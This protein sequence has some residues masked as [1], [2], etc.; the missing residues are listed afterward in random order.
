MVL[1]LKEGVLTP[2]SSQI[3]IELT[4][5]FLLIRKHVVDLTIV[6]LKP[7]TLTSQFLDLGTEE[8]VAGIFEFLKLLISL[9]QLEGKRLAFL[10]FTLHF[11]TH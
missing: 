2:R 1:L 4:A 3:L 11:S 5:L 7:L 8:A 9:D 10:P 6:H